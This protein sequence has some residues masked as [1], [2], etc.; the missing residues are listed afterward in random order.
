MTIKISPGP[1]GA[2][3][4]V[5][6]A[7]NDLMVDH[8]VALAAGGGA[9][10]VSQPI[11]RFLL[12][13]NDLTDTDFLAKAAPIGWRYLILGPGPIAVADVKEMQ[14]GAPSF[15]SLIHGEIAD[16]LAKASELAEQRYG[17]QANEF[18]ARILEIPSIH[19]SALWLHGPEDI[20][21]P[22]IEKDPKDPLPP[23]EDPSFILRAARAAA[24]KRSQMQKG[25]NML[26]PVEESELQRPST[27]SSRRRCN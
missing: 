19:M 9:T 18:E 26:N 22:I 20:F 13:L 11:Q 12:K 25:G 1:A 23:H 2:I 5:E 4:V 14:S 6:G 15:D 10:Q 17:A 7:V 16:R 24:T 27:T 3:Q 21:I 8:T